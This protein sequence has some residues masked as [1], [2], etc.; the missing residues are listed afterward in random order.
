MKD[1]IAEITKKLKSKKKRN[2]DRFKKLETKLNKWFERV[3]R[4]R[5]SKDYKISKNKLTKSK[6]MTDIQSKVQHIIT[7]R[8]I[9]TFI[10]K[11]INNKE[12]VSDKADHD[13]RIPVSKAFSKQTNDLIKR[14]ANKDISNK[15]SLNLPLENNLSVYYYRFPLTNNF[16][17]L[18]K[19]FTRIEE[20]YVDICTDKNRIRTPILPQ[21]KYISL[22]KFSKAYEHRYKK[23][24]SFISLKK[25]LAISDAFFTVKV[26][27]DASN[28]HDMNNYVIELYEYKN[29]EEYL[30]NNAEKQ[31]EEFKKKIYNFLCYKHEEMCQYMKIKFEA[32]KEQTWIPEFDIDFIYDSLIYVFPI[33]DDYKEFLNQGDT[34][35][36]E[37]NKNELSNKDKVEL[38]REKILSKLRKKNQELAEISDK[39]N[40]PNIN[41]EMV[42]DVAEKIHALMT[43]RKI[44]NIYLTTA[45]NHF[46]NKHCLKYAM[47]TQEIMYSIRKIVA[48][49]PYWLK[50]N[51]YKEHLMLKM[52]SDFNLCQIINYIKNH[53][54]DD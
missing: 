32:F 8:E 39:T 43:I 51:E 50:I 31:A 22:Q 24:F 3:A 27:K 19:E 9:N 48:I 2:N 40:I 35:V 46:E 53:Y 49:M 18:I 4:N 41:R 38:L 42:L 13:G 54:K 37:L 6:Q 44:S 7:G 52:N 23:L 15:N 30:R 11:T 28:P 45:I 17:S 10:N 26:L 36:A 34:I 20:L 47:D 1:N 16:V 5:I 14:A 12:D 29:I 25:I 21:N 33:L